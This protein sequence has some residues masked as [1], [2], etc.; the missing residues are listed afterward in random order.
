MTLLQLRQTVPRSRIATDQKLAERC[1]TISE[2]LP[3]FTDLHR[4][5]E[6]T[7]TQLHLLETLIGAA[8]WYLPEMRLKLWTGLISRKAVEA[9][10]P[11]S[12]STEPKLTSDH[13]VPRKI[14]AIE[15]IEYFENAGSMNGQEVQN[16][17]E[18]RFGKI[19]FVTSTENKVVVKYQRVENYISPSSAYKRA[20][21]E[22]L[23]ISID[24]YRL[25]CRRDPEV[26]DSVLLQ[27]AFSFES[28]ERELA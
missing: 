11:I 27:P 1:H 9:F 3:V 26:I 4:S 15:L 28:M 13:P 22:L 8:L 23:A 10:H 21:I 12:G 17:Y 18:Q 19:I 16:L 14:A 20:G 24:Q 5:P 6:S 2:L 7:D 25:I